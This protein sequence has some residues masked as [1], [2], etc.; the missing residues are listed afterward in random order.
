MGKKIFALDLGVTSIGWA[1]VDEKTSGRSIL[2]LGSRIIPLSVDDNNEFSTGNAISKNAKRTQ[3]R[4]QRKGYDRYQLRRQNLIVF[5]EQNGLMPDQTLMQLPPLSLWGLRAKSA[6]EKITAVELGRVL[7]HLNQKRGYRSS[8]A[9]ESSTDKKETEYVAEVMSRYAQ[10]KESGHTLGQ[11]FLRALQEA[12]DRHIPYRIKQQVYPRQA[13]LEEFNAIIAEQRKYHRFLNDD[14]IEHLR[15]NIIYYQRPLKSQKGLV[16]ICEFE[17]KYRKNAKGNEVFTGPKVSPRSSP[18]AQ[19]GKIWETVNNIRITNKRGEIYTI[20]PEQKKTLVAYLNQNERMSQLKL[21]ELLSLKSLDGWIGNKQT[22]K[23][24]QG[25]LTHCAIITLLS[26]GHPALQFNLAINSTPEE[27]Y[28]VDAKTGEIK[29]GTTKKTIDPSFEKE[30]FYRLWHSIYSIPDVKECT[31]VLQSHF[32]IDTETALQLARLDFT[33]GGFSNKSAAALRKY[34][35][36]LMEGFGY[37]EAMSLAGYNHSSSVTKDENLKRQLLNRVPLLKRNNLRQPV[38]EKILNQMIGVVNEAMEKWGQFTENDEIRI[39]L[40]RE[41][42]QS[43]DERNDTFTALNKREKENQTIRRRIETEYAEYGVRA[44]RNTLIKWRLFHEINNDEV[45]TN[46]TCIYCGQPFGITEA[47]RGGN[48]DVEHIIPRSKIFDD[49]QSNKTL[50]HRA[51]NDNKGDRTAYDYM[52]SKG[53]VE[54][55]YYLDRV[56]AL[57]K[58]KIIGKRKRD[59]LLRSEKDIPKDF[60]ER[61]LRE[62][63][64]IARKAKEIL[65]QVCYNVWSTSGSVTEYLRRVWGWDQVLMNLRLQE[66]REAGQTEWIEKMNEARQLHQVEIIK[67]WTK[68]DDH[69]HHAVDALTI[70]CTQQGFIQR[71]NTL[72]AAK[73]REAMRAELN[74]SYDARRNLLENYVSS[75]RP[76]TTAQVEEVVSK[77]LVSFKPGKRVA[78]VS[79]YK[80]KGKNVE[81]GVIVPRGALSEESVYGRIQTIEKGKPVKYLFENPHLIYKQYIKDLVEQRL[82]IHNNDVKKAL[83]SLKKEPIYLDESKTVFLHYGT[84]YRTEYVIKYPLA[85]LLPKDA[86]FII[87]SHIRNLVAHRFAEYKGDEKKA[88]EKPLYSDKARQTEIRSVRCA[89]GLTAVEAVKK[90]EEGNDIGFV[91]PGNNHHLAIYTNAEGNKVEH[92]C[93]FWHA[94][95]RKKFGFTPI[96]IHSQKVWDEI[97]PKAD[98]YSQSFLQKLPQAQ[99]VFNQSMQQNEMFLI[100]LTQAGASE[101]IAADDFALLSKHLYRVQKISST[102]YKLVLRHHLATTID[103]EADMRGYASPAKFD[104]IKVHINKTGDI[105]LANA[106]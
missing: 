57:Y 105:R 1:M 11:H 31:S 6:T 4:S 37:S 18:L 101:A 83:S 61:Q 55:G 98:E 99:W 85:I 64:Y 62:T 68:R 29:Q 76:F 13:Y 39:E 100:G 81:S 2:G 59:N 71:L 60:I 3:K 84:C 44:T 34:L 73:T 87:D 54:L 10:L 63:Q 66:F 14:C 17:G 24:L 32:N 12:H 38:V 50:V 30:P 91:K 7:Y 67:G 25:N 26:S 103:R 94:V 74:D 89:T 65:E 48:V 9:D 102:G 77:V 52:D 88:F 22:S 33:K 20:T 53:A 82:A 15:S 23:G 35:P 97:L 8:R 49:S 41:L 16:C 5:L 70:A 75:K 58:A 21:F 79:K 80:A 42:K 104:G 47:L 51:C 93:S 69:R 27:V 72:N 95:E 96:I 78:T 86:Q 28:V 19:I 43:K 40:A 46:A 45:K 92:I 106:Q 56:D 36:Y 90:D